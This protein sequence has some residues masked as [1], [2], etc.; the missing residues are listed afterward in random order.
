MT[1]PSGCTLR[2]AEPKGPLNGCEGICKVFE[3]CVELTRE[4]ATHEE[5]R[6]IEIERLRK[7]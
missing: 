3:L 1:K 5:W 6:V 7:L 4:E 2:R